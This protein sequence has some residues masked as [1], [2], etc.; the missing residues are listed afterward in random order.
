M[1]TNVNDESALSHPQPHTHDINVKKIDKLSSTRVRLTV[2][3]P[4]GTLAKREQSL[5]R[6]YASQAKI[7][8]FRPGKAPL[9]MIQNKYREEI[10]RDVLSHLLESGLAAA[11]EETKLNPVSQPTLNV[12]S[13]TFDNGKPFEFEAEFD[14]QPEIAL[15]D[16]KGIPLASRST[17]VADEELDKALSDLQERLAFLEPIESK[18]ATKGDHAVAEISYFLPALPDKKEAAKPYTVEVGM[19]KLLPELD[20]ALMELEVGGMTEVKTKFPDDYDDKTLSGHDA[21][22]EVKLIELKKKVLPELN[23]AFASQLKEGSTLAGIKD[24]IRESLKSGKEEENEKNRRNDIIEYLINQNS[25]E[26][27]K[28]M[29]EK[30]GQMLVG[31][32]RDDMKKRGYPATPIKEEE[33]KSVEKRAE[34][35][36]K[37]SLLLREI[38][39]KEN[40]TLDEQ[41]LNQRIETIAGKLNRSVDDTRKWLSGKGMLD[42][43]NDEILTDQIFNFLSKHAQVANVPAGFK[44]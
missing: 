14:I 40:I 22:F 21:V 36:V 30:Q 9:Q 19:G 12:T 16:Y 5:V 34:F 23:D 13:V 27:P 31:W 41:L 2:E 37:S 44:K 28:S 18:K 32:M 33:M 29:V 10:R 26:V 4:S 42:K 43:L 15:K 17:E 38:A 39:I 11:L 3:Y 20:N 7:P 1:K 35:M 24:E 8:G 6:R 25:F